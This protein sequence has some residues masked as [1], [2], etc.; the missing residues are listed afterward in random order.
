MSNSI[1]TKRFGWF[2]SVIAVFYL[3]GTMMLG[4]PSLARKH[5]FTWN[6][7]FQPKVERLAGSVSSEE[8]FI[9]ALR[10][11]GFEMWMRPENPI[12]GNV[13]SYKDRDRNFTTYDDFVRRH[14]QFQAAF[15]ENYRIH[16]RIAETSYGFI[17]CA[18]KF[19]I[20][21]QLENDQIVDLEARDHWVCL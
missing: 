16:P 10:R 5:P 11:R 2:L 17:P 9:A 18:R 15:P 12:N 1:W 21:W 6:L 3:L 8:E 4:P 7:S 19:Q 14:E 20:M 13:T